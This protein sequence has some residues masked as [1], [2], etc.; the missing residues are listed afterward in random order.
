[1]QSDHFDQIFK[2]GALGVGVHP[3]SFRTRKLSPLPPMVLI[4]L[5]RVGKRQL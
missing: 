1:M 4:Y 3:F 5:G 2:V